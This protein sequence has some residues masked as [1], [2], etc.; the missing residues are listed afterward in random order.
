MGIA[1]KIIVSV[2][3]LVLVVGCGG[4]VYLAPLPAEATLP[5]KRYFLEP[6]TITDQRMSLEFRQN[7]ISIYEER[8]IKKL[9]SLDKL[10]TDKSS[11]DYVLM[12]IVE[13]YYKR[14]ADKY[15]SPFGGGPRSDHMETLVIVRD[16]ESGKELSRGRIFYRDPSVFGSL[17]NMIDSSIDNIAAYITGEGKESE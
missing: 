15:L 14:N 17:S 13:K 1:N 5:E 9:T 7:A 2:S 16:P 10:A 4:H 6:I 11:A 3:I 8:I 12:L